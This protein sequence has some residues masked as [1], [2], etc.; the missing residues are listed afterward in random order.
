M[1]SHER[2]SSVA[3]AS[4]AAE[5]AVVSA[6]RGAPGWVVWTLSQLVDDMSDRDWCKPGKGCEMCDEKRAIR[7]EL[8]FRSAL[9]FIAAAYV[10]ALATCGR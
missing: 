3:S 7:S 4:S 1:V 2:A 9:A 6:L 8:R 10:V 5:L